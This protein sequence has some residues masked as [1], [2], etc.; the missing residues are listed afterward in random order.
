MTKA[1]IG[2][3]CLKSTKLPAKDNNYRNTLA[4]EWQKCIQKLLSL[5]Q[6]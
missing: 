4:K 5:P 1:L 2:F 3:A 6:Q